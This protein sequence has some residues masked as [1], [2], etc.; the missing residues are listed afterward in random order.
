ME[1]HSPVGVTGLSMLLGTLMLRAPDRRRRW[2]RCTG[3]RSARAPGSR[4]STRRLFARQ[5]RLHDLVRGGARDRQRADVRL[6]EPAA[7]RRD[8][9]GG[10]LAGGTAGPDQSRR[11]RGCAGRGR[12]RTAR[13]QPYNG[14]VREVPLLLA[15]RGRPARRSSAP[16]SRA[17]RCASCTGSRRCGTSRSPCASS[18]SW[19]SRRGRLI[20]FETRSIWVPL[21][22]VQ[23]F[24]IFN[25]TVLLHEVVHH[26]I[27]ERRH[28]RA[29]RAA[30]I[31]LRDPERHLRLQFTRWHLDH[32][33]ELGSDEDDP[34]RAHL[35]PKV[36][37]RWYK[38]LYCTPALFPIYF[39]AA[40][41]ESSTYPAALQHAINRERKIS[42]AAHLVGDC[43]RLG[44]VRLLCGA[45]D[46]HH[47]GVL[48]L[49]DRVHA[50]PSRPALRHRSRPIRPNGAR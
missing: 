22:F 47:P 31:P 36:N 21:A 44:A 37:K 26:T 9:D 20:R 43:A 6:F 17:S 1:R 12:A 42:M 32:H 38:L 50:E 7:D 14:S 41:R 11:G 24:T 19:R 45:A 30:R 4:C 23:G 39:R 27:F 29:E 49:S 5:R 18:R 10:V 25:F 34:K 15:A 33:A 3:R 46:E 13:F 48:H 2:C 8:G 28:P 40:R 35:S 16:P